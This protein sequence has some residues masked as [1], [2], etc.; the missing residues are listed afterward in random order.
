[1]NG[2]NAMPS[3]CAYP[4]IQNR[5][6]IAFHTVSRSKLVRAVRPVI[7]LCM[8]HPVLKSLPL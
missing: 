7:M 6:T 8:L 4:S 3:K 2:D 5:T 1:M